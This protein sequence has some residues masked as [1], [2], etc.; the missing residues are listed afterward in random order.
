MH[1]GSLTRR[2]SSLH[3]N[4]Q[5]KLIVFLTLTDMLRLICVE[6]VLMLSSVQD[7]PYIVLIDDFRVYDHSLCADLASQPTLTPG[8]RY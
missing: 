6:T 2:K 3:P 8:A 1:I 7:G 5:W 4:M